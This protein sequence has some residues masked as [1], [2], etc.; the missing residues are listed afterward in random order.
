MNYRR[1][2]LDRQLRKRIERI[3]FWSL[4]LFLIFS[5]FARNNFK[6]VK[7]P[8][9]ELFSEPIRSELEDSSPIEFSRE[10]F[11]FTLTPLYEY[12]MSA[13]V[14]NRLDYRWFS[15][16]RASEAFPMDLCVTWGQNVKN[17]SYRHRSV[18]FRQDFRF[19]FGNWSNE[20]KFRWAEVSNN[21]LIIKDEN[22]LRKA[23]TISEGDQIRLKGKLVNVKAEN[24]D[25]NLGKYEAQISN[26]NSSVELGDSGAGACEVVLVEEL[27]II[28]KANPFFFYG[29]QFGSY[30]LIAF[31]TWKI[32]GFF[33]EIIRKK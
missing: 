8:S 16:T 13:L 20:A 17:G 3:F 19:C 23:M 25:G 31:I 21:H 33:S 15:L 24:K 30:L 10:G 32:A 12:E 2:E 1:I 7:S 6:S 18:N 26:W 9:P 4:V 14:V 27:E 28:K 29:F 11:E 22:I 5:F